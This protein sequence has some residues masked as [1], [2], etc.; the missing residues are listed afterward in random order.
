MKILVLRFSSIGDIV[1]TSPVLRGLAQQVKGAEV[2]MAT[3]LAGAGTYFLPFNLGHDQGAGNPP[4]PAGYRTSY[5][6]ERILEREAWLEQAW[7]T[8]SRP[9]QA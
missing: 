1:L 4:N 9:W 7:W 5:L 6:W 8:V 3:K 2:H